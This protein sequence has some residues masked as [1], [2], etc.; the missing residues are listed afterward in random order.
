M[1]SSPTTPDLFSVVQSYSKLSIEDYQRTY[2]WEKEQIDDFFEDL[3]DCVTSGETHFFGTL[4]L[5]ENE[6]NRDEA[7]VVDGQQRLT[8]T[9]I[10]V[11]GLRDAIAELSSQVIEP[12]KANLRPV[13][14]MEKA[15]DYLC[16]SDDLDNHRFVSSRY[17]HD[18]MENSVLAEPGKRKPLPQRDR[19]ISLAF[20][21]GV[22]QLR[23]LIREDLV[24][25]SDDLAKLHRVNSLLDALYER[26]LVLRVTTNSLGESLDIFLTLN[27]RGLPLGPS[28]LV[29]G[30]LMSVRGMGKTDQEQVKIQKTILEEWQIIVENVTEPEAFLRHYLVATSKDKVQKKK[31]VT[32]VSKRIYDADIEQ[33]QKNAEEFWE[34]LITASVYYGQ[35]LNPTMGG[36]CQYHLQLLKGLAKS[37]NVI[38]MEVL[39]KE[40]DSSERDE[41]V[42]L[43]FV[44]AFRWVMA[45]LNAQKLED[46]YQI[47]CGTLREGGTATDVQEALRK[48]IADIDLNPKKYFS[49]DADSAYATRALLHAINKATTKGSVSI[50]L[51]SK[52]LHLEHIAPQ[53]ESDEWLSDLF[54]GDESQFSKYESLI[55]SAGNLTLL[56]VG[57]NLQAQKKP[58]AAK[59]IEYKKS[60]MDVARDLL[61]FEKWDKSMIEERTTWLAEMF[62]LIWSPVRASTQVV[63]FT[64]WFKAR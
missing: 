16:P 35:V 13:N 7:T 47:Q 57:L 60:T 27:N 52:N 30:E 40:F 23:E 53:S 22:R 64:E 14:V 19:A 46:L 62:E 21:K 59:K 32:T 55:G 6:K 36:E 8:T 44:L 51:D 17:L 37:H 34:D 39:R 9:F 42:R 18:L 54:N 38:L 50:Q 11:A 41:I 5:Q 58:F 28:D 48:A 2:S 10:L 20:R 49:S 63:S 25:F 1:K 15:W 43:V 4:I 12:Q 24:R 33:R 3:K 45:G 31:V 29:R 56:D 61:D 26:F